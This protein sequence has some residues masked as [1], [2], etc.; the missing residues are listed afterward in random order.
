MFDKDGDGNLDFGE[1]EALVQSLGIETPA[2]ARKVRRARGGGG[3]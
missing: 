2:D 1:F 3:D